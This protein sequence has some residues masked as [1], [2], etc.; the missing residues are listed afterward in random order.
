[1]VAIIHARSP[2]KEQT[3][4]MVMSRKRNNFNIFNIFN[5]LRKPSELCS[6]AR[7]ELSVC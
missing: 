7:H 3:D 5:I 2:L 4:L 6:S 1:M